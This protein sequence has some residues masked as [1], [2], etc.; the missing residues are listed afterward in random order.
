MMGPMRLRLA[1]LCLLA[2]IPATADSVQVRIVTDDGMPLPESSVVRL[3]CV[4]SETLSEMAG[5]SGTVVLETPTGQT[6]CFLEA[7]APSY[8]R[9]SLDLDELP[10]DPRIPALVLHRLGKNQGETIGVS[11]LAAPDNAVHSFHAAVRELREREDGDIEAAL[12]HLDAAVR[13]YPDYAQA[14]YEIGRLRLALGDAAR[15]IGAFREAVRADPWYVS[16]YEP[17]ILLLEAAGDEA[18]AGRVCGGLRRINPELPADC[19]RQ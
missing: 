2:A 7:A 3:Q 19:G 13:A 12:G 11:H 4:G 6:D 17:L 16:P 8:R 1:I 9:A 5:T 15:A 10:L 14:W 18:A